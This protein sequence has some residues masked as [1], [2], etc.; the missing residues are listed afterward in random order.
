MIRPDLL[1]L[2][3]AILVITY[4]IIMILLPIFVASIS[5]QV[6]LIN[7]KMDRVITIFERMG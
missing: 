4:A 6:K 2:I 1:Y 3:V 5:R 7:R